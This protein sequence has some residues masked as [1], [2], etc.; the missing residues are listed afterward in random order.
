[1]TRRF[2]LTPLALACLALPLA[3]GACTRAPSS[4]PV[5]ADGA[6]ATPA[7]ATADAR[8][9]I[10]SA[11]TGGAIAGTSFGPEGPAA[12]G[13][14][15]A[16]VAPGSNNQ[17]AQA[18]A[19]PPPAPV[20]A[21]AA[22]A[23]LAADSLLRA[24]VL[25]ERAYFSPGEIDGASGSNTRR[26]IAAFQAANG[27]TASGQLD[28]ATWQALGGDDGPVLIEHTLTADDVAGPFRATPGTPMEMAKLDALPYASVE[29][30]V[31]EQFHM[32]PALLAE[33]NPGI[34]L[35]AGNKITVPHVA[36]G[37]RLPTPAKVV[38]DKSDSVLQLHDAD[39][40][41][42]AQFPV[43]TGSAEFPLPIGEWKVTGVARN[44]VWHYD[45]KLISGSRPGDTKAEIPPGP[46]NP[47]GTTWIGISK[48]HYGIH[49][50]PEPSRIGK[51]ASN[52]CIRMTNWSA[53]ALAKVVSPGMQVTLR[54]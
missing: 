19:E 43:T 29:E 13:G 3:L 18:E 24:Q 27:L 32:S 21:A 46:N 23:N 25:L 6:P 8:G 33:Y 4:D 49:G 16:P 9:A 47:V 11:N 10:D 17:D 48:P 34:A 40:K 22:D 31:A 52:G 42:L 50:T 30:K 1:M 39:G 7:D 37:A 5:V 38:V 12:E 36:P 15:V 51:T 41:V 54:E 14:A 35:E 53:A 2:P 44:P 26:A 28:E 20:T 45:P